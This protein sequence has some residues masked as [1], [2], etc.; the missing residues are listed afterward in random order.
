MAHAAVCTGPVYPP[1]PE[2]PPPEPEPPPPPGLVQCPYCGQWETE[3]TIFWHIQTAHPPYTKRVT[4]TVKNT[5]SR[6]GVGTSATLEVTVGARLRGIERIGPFVSSLAFGPGET[7]TL[8]FDITIEVQDFG[9]T[10]TLDA[11]V[12]RPDG[13]II[14]SDTKL[15]V[16]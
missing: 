12:A 10:M 7:K 1:E 9:N 4:V 3:E 5:S 15:E 16:V 6:G 8:L 2:P 13:G 14:T 11:L